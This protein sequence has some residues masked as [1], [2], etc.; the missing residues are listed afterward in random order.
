[1]NVKAAVADDEAT[2]AGLPEEGGLAHDDMALDQE[3]AEALETGG[4]E[5]AVAGVKA[6]SAA[7]KEPAQEVAGDRADNAH[8]TKWIDELFFGGDDEPAAQPPPPP[9][10]P[11]QYYQPQQQQPL[12]QP[13]DQADPVQQLLDA[14]LRQVLGPL[15]YEQHMLKQ[16]IAREHN[17][18]VARELALAANAMQEHIREA[19]KDPAMANPKVRTLFEMELKNFA[20]EAKRSAEAGNFSMIN[21]MRRPLFR[22]M[23]L[24]G[25]K[26][27]AGYPTSGGPVTA[28]MQATATPPVRRNDAADI[29]FEG[30]L[31]GDFVEALRS[32]Y[33]SGWTAKAKKYIE[34]R[35]KYWGGQ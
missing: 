6:K 9:P 13:E 21:D 28:A 16:W 7:E 8:E 5:T 32:A 18:R 2:T 34:A 26:V 30:Q 15:V 3:T 20:K 11:P 1:M 29:D 35:K 14:R 24:T 22:E 23:V 19:S 27:L 31:G 33:G 4:A 17:E 10:Q 25:A 12:Q